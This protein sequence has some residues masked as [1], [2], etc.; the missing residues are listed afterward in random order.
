[1]NI[2]SDDLS[3][4]N[5]GYVDDKKNETGLAAPLTQEAE[6]VAGIDIKFY[7]GARTARGH[8][9]DPQQYKFSPERSRSFPT[10]AECR[11]RI[12]EIHS[13]SERYAGPPLPSEHLAPVAVQTIFYSE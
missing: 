2:E 10:L 13:E 1:M 3:S 4:I 9:F 5:D 7:I 12:R 6:G 11:A 8:E